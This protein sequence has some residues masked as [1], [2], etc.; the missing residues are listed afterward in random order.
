M[1]ELNYITLWQK[2]NKISSN[3]SHIFAN[4]HGR[5][6]VCFSPKIGVE[7]WI[8]DMGICWRGVQKG[9]EGFVGGLVGW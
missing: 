2:I 9:V 8:A 3:F 1:H 5:S 4:A 7:S 6:Y